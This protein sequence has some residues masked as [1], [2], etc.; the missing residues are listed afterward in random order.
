MTQPPEP[1]KLAAS[2]VTADTVQDE[3]L[4]VQHHPSSLRLSAMFH[5]N[6][7]RGASAVRP[8]LVLNIHPVPPLD[9]I[10]HLS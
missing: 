1:T 6:T 5:H 3:A 8:A 9:G 4:W 7:Q 10:L 2:V